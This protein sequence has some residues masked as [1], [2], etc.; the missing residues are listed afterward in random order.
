MTSG[1]PSLLQISYLAT[2]GGQL[3]DQTV[4]FFDL[5]AGIP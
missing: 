2:S 3:R 4:H 1:G 5:C